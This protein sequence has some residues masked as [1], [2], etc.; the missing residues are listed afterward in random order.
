[1]MFFRGN[2]I[3]LDRVI[4]LGF[5]QTTYGQ[6]LDMRAAEHGLERKLATKA[7]GTKANNNPL[8]IIGSNG[9]VVPLGS[10]FTTKAGIVFKTTEEVVIGESGQ[11]YVD[12]EADVAGAS[13]NV[14]AGTITEIPI[15]IPGVTS[16][17]NENPTTGGTDTETDADLLARLLEKVRLPATSGNVAHYLQWA[18]EV[19]GVGDAKVIPTWNGPGTVKVIVIDSNKQP[20]SA[21]IVTAV[22]NHIEEVRP[23][24]ATVTVISAAGLVINVSVV[25]ILDQA[26]TLA[27]V[28][29]VIETAIANYL[30]EIAFRQDYVSYAKIGSL[31]L[32]TPGVLDY[33]NLTLNGGTANVSV[34]TEQVAVLGTV[35]LAA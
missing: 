19:N 33:S 29:P 30:K 5:A 8:K 26:Y 7:T 28:Q 17:M 23:I 14:P 27:Q 2:Y 34:G 4:K 11:V 6:Y 18:K 10:I 25:L 22:A 21:D 9:T 35:T 16:V 24:G 1:M 15:S 12:I 31:I 32:E 13:G 3:E 20:A